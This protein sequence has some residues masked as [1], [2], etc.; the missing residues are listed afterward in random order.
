[1]IPQVPDPI[2]IIDCILIADGRL[3]VLVKRD[4]SQTPVYQ[5]KNKFSA[6][7]RFEPN[8]QVARLQPVV[9]RYPEPV[10]VNGNHLPVSQDSDTNDAKLLHR[11]P[12]ALKKPADACE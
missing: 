12:T 10:L 4:C 2:G 5:E 8:F 1:M 9:G 7:K 6:V 3:K 11:H